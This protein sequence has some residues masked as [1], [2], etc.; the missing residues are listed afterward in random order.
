[1]GSLA[2]PGAAER[3]WR[4][5]RFAA[6]QELK[7]EIDLFKAWEFAE[8]PPLPLETDHEDC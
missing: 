1:M 8:W 5:K 3:A 7:L 2:Q 6:I 4:D